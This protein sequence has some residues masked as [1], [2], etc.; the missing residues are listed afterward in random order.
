MNG[1]KLAALTLMSLLAAF[2]RPAEADVYK[3][4]DEDGNVT[5]T[6][7]PPDPDAQPLKLR[8]LSIVERPEYKPPRSRDEEDGAEG[9]DEPSLREL[10][11]EYR[12][13]RLVS[14]EPDQSFWGTGNVATIA[15]ESR[16]A[17]RPGMTV[18]FFLDG[19]P[20]GGPTVNPVLATEPLDRGEHQATATLLTA[21]GQAVTTAGP[22]TFHIKQ[23]SRLIRRGG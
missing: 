22:V 12:D 2:A 8:Q 14:P 6:D 1:W 16:R 5:F 4:V 18:Q 19:Q 21:N 7:R 23:Q 20:V 10:R 17:L 11:R 13:F 3:I 15:W 9:D